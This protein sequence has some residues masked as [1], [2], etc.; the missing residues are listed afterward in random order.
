[1]RW[2][3]K[4]PVKRLK[5]RSPLFAGNRAQPDAFGGRRGGIA[6]WWGYRVLTEAAIRALKPH[7]KPYKRS[8]ARGL[9]IL[10]SVT[11]ARLWRYKY[12]HG[13]VERL[14]TLGTYPEV[15]LRD[16][17]DA[18]DEARR[19]LK[20][21][22]DPNAVKRATR[23]KGGDSFEAVA[24]EWLG[25][26]THLSAGTVK[27]DL[28]RLESF[29]FP[30][31]GAK[32]IIAITAPD[33]LAEL[34]RIEARGTLETA[35]RTKAVV[36]RIL[37]Y[38][39]AT[40]RGERDHAADLK[41]ALE[42]TVVQ[43]FPAIVD[44]PRIGEL[45]RAMDSYRGQPSAEYALRMLPYVFVR[46]V[47]LRRARWD[48]FDLEGAL[49]RIPAHRM[50][51]KRE[52]LVPLAR[53]VVAMLKDL[54]PITGDGA[55][56]FPG[57]RTNQRPISEVTLNAALRRLGVAKEEHCPHGFRST[58]STRLNE[59]GWDPALIE[60]QLAHAKKDKVAAVYNRA[61]RL[62]ERTVMM[63]AWADYLDGLK[64]A[65]LAATP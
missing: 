30:R 20:A 59:M 26:Q 6:A 1:M 8:D 32:P 54:L 44:P 14:L 51:R 39:I 61:L 60:L 58:A 21:G 11:G 27:R 31:L 7:E 4:N 38:G 19:L 42:Q 49:W 15:G 24:R 64:A 13:G 41:G 57:L 23:G 47:E 12:R 5:V 35:H 10:V 65:A 17:R 50:K 34:R 36:G 22:Q 48:E 29:I 56:L 52:H 40:G 2:G 16:A 46:P 28:D 25:K 3:W 45:L 9:F 63:Q 62:A 55:L 53:Q 43:S 33:L 37:R 18:R